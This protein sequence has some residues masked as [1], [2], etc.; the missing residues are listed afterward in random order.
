MIKSGCFFTSFI[1]HIAQNCTIKTI[2]KAFKINDNIFVSVDAD[3]RKSTINRYKYQR[4]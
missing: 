3:H 2:D 4:R 1:E